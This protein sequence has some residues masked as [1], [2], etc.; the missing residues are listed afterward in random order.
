MQVYRRRDEFETLGAQPIVICFYSR[1]A[2]RAWQDQTGVQLPL[3]RD[4]DKRTYADYELEHSLR[5]AFSLRNMW[6]YVKAFFQGK[7]IPRPGPDKGQLG[8]DFIVGADG[9]LRYTFYSEDPTER[10]QVDELLRQL[11]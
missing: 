4:P 2:A 9:R 11:R 3:L 8:G 1:D 10:P 6:S 5:R 7:K